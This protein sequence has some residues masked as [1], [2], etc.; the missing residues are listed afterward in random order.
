MPIWWLNPVW[1]KK[2]RLW[3]KLELIA[4]LTST[5]PNFITATIDHEIDP[6]MGCSLLT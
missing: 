4:I 5:T 6:K 1:K 3:Y 2:L